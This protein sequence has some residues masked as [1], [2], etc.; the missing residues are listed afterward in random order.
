MAAEQTAR[1]GHSPRLSAHPAA[2]PSGRP[3]RGIARRAEAPALAWA[4]LVLSPGI[5]PH[6]TPGQAIL[7]RRLLAG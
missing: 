6:A 7:A 3:R 5:L 1:R 4:R 2:L